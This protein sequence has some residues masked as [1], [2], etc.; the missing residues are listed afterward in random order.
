MFIVADNLA[1]LG[2]VWLIWGPYVSFIRYSF[3]GLVLNEIKNND[4]L[5]SGSAYIENLGFHTLGLEA[6]FFIMILFVIVLL[7]LQYVILRTINYENR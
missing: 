1:S 5:P 3:Q 6:C 7:L 4:A 2:T